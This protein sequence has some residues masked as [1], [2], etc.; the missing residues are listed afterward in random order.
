MRIR[1]LSAFFGLRGLLSIIR[2]WLSGSEMGRGAV[3]ARS[4]PG[5]PGRADNRSRPGALLG[6]LFIRLEIGE[7]ESG[8]MGHGLA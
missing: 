3:R 6:R 4:V 7:D 8:C 5:A 2:R 1:L